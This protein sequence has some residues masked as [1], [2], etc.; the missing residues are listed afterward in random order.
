MLIFA[1]K[2]R[3]CGYRNPAPQHGILALLSGWCNKSNNIW[4]H[5]AVHVMFYQHHLSVV[6]SLVSKCINNSTVSVKQLLMAGAGRLLLG[7]LL[8]PL[9]CSTFIM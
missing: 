6:I 8:V 5:T 2:T 1:G 3:T 4:L 7:L 9:L